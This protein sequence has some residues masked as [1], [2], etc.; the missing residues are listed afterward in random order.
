MHLNLNFYLQSSGGAAIQF[1]HYNS[2][3]RFILLTFDAVDSLQAKIKFTN[4]N[5]KCTLI[6][7]G[8]QLQKLFIFL[9]AHL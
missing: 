2:F 9:L 1:S 7:D 4:T 5:E 6:T 3:F 8:A